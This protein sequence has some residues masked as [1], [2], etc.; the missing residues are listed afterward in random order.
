MDEAVWFDAFFYA[1]VVPV[2]YVETLAD[3]EKEVADGKTPED[4]VGMLADKTPYNA[5]SNVH[6][7]QL[8]LAE[9]VGETFQTAMT[10]GQ[11]VIGAG[12]TREA[13]DGSVGLH[14]DEFPEAAALL[15][16]RNRDFLEIERAV[17]KSWREE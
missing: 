9:L 15:R 7:R 16:W 12:D 1:N 10:L 6:H 5:V 11:P 14:V 2:F 3:L 17:A 4:L 8:V 13:T